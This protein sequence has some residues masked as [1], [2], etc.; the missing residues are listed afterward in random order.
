[1]SQ[2]ETD[3]AA[4]RPDGDAHG[5]Y[6]VTVKTPAG[7][8]DPFHV[9]G[10]MK[11]ETLTREAVNKFSSAGQLATGN[12]RLV[13]LRDGAATPLVASSSLGDDGVVAGDELALVTADPQKDG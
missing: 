11:V 2:P 12:Y 9:T 5:S 13:L 4:A 10:A 6:T 1:M 7:F 8:S 3:Q